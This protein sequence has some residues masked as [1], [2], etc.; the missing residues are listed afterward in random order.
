MVEGA[1]RGARGEGRG[2][3][4]EGREAT[5]KYRPNGHQRKRVPNL[6]ADY[7]F[8]KLSA[9]FIRE[10]RAVIIVLSC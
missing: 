1:R 7:V 3:R 8:S 10:A 4:G 9:L 2:A 5:T 6:D